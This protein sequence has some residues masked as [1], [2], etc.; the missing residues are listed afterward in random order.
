MEISRNTIIDL[1]PLYIADEA[2]P[3]TRHLIE[4]YLKNDPD[5]AEIVKKLSASE[6]PNEIPIPINKEREMEAY[7]EAK[8]QQRKYVITLVGVIA[9]IFLIMM[10]AALGGLFLLLPRIW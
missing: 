3:E 4:L 10:A 2:S 9:I 6:I 1:L 8:L 5:L 7:E